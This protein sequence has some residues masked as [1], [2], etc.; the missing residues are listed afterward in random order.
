MIKD[1]VDPEQVLKD[2]VA[3][4]KKRIKKLKEK[5]SKKQK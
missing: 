4:Q 3:N 5:C 1:K 2:F